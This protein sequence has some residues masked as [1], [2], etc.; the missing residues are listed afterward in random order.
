MKERNLNS[1]LFE[2][3]Q[4]TA[5]AQHKRERKKQVER[6]RELEG[7]IAACFGQLRKL[8]L[9]QEDVEALAYS[10]SQARSLYANHTME[11]LGD[12]IANWL[13]LP[14]GCNYMKILVSQMICV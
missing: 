8:I 14:S 6:L 3:D 12:V 4:A 13:G 7:E 5:F 2:T 1:L 9:A 11:Q 10:D